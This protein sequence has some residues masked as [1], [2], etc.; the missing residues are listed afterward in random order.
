MILGEQ[1]EGKIN[2]SIE[3][4]ESRDNMIIYYIIGPYRAKTEREVV[5]NIRNAEVYA[6]EVW[7]SRNVAICPHLNS[8]LMGGICP[9][10]YFLRGDIEILK[11][12]DKAIAIP[13]WVYSVG[14]TKE[15]KITKLA[16]IEVFFPCDIKHLITILKEASMWG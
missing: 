11:R 2:Y 16:K 3:I 4:K 14:S 9:D 1:Y 6:M 15:V 8:R 5:T 7:K 13:G 12:C 10:E